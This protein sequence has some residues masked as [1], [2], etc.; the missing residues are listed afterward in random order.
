MEW[1]SWGAKEY[2]KEL[3]SAKNAGFTL[4]RMVYKS[5]LTY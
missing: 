5:T 1:Q 4:C 2:K 3:K